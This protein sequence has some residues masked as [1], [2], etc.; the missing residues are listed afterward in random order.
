MGYRSMSRAVVFAVIAL[1]L[2]TSLAPGFL[3]LASHNSLSKLSFRYAFGPQ[4]VQSAVGIGTLERQRAIE[5]FNQREFAEALDLLRAVVA[6]DKEDH[7]AWY[8]LGFALT[9]QKKFKDASKAFE[10][11]LKLRPN[12]PAAHSGLGYSFLLRSKLP[13]AIREAQA[14]LKMDP[15]LAEAYYVIGVARLRTDDQ[16]EALHNAEAALK[17]NSRFANAYLLKSQALT[18]FLGEALVTDISET[19][20]TRRTRFE[21]AAEALEKYLELAP[22][23]PEKSTWNVQLEALRFH[24]KWFAKP[25]QRTVFSG[26]AVITKARVLNKPAPQFPE[27]ARASGTR[28][29]VVLKAIFWSDGTVKH[30]LVLKGLPHGLTEASIRAAQG[31]KFVPAT[32]EGRNVSTVI[33]LEYNFNLF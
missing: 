24:S 29:M 32:I 11:A 6:K 17:I 9:Q 27:D 26:G 16:K 2:V 28:G 14:A 18:T 4:S 33:Q 31:I 12:F 3:V 1:P 8:Y 30:I 23:S 5:L 15:N 22:N 7:V 10:T 19:S 20:E 13:D 25:S 21:Q